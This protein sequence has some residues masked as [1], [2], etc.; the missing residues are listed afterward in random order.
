M[1]MINCPDCKREVSDKATSC[2]GCGYPL[3]QAQQER[4][5]SDLL[6][7]KRW[8]ARSQTLGGS[9]LE[10]MFMPNGKFNGLLMPNTSDPNVVMI[11]QHVPLKQQINGTWQVIGPQ[12]VLD[13]A[14]ITR[15]HSGFVSSNLKPIQFT[16]LSED[17]LLGVDGSGRVWEWAKIR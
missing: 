8:Q 1:A 12:L 7:G 9:I 15:V 16:Q 11:L 14:Y 4:N 17:K 13:Y 2:P 5:L 3:Q 6:I 10:V